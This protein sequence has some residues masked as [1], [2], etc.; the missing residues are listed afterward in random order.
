MEELIRVLAR[1][2][3]I[4]RIADGVITAQALVQQMHAGCT[5]HSLEPPYPA[6]CRDPKDDYLIALFTQSQP[7]H[8]ITGDK[9]LLV[10]KG[11][12]PAILTA[13]EFLDRL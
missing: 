2:R 4:L 13:T 11:K 6:V 8:F 12:W 3:I 1:P 9:D 7:M 10:L 5:F